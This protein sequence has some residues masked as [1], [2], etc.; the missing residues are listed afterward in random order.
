MPETAARIIVTVLAVYVTAGALFALAF[1]AA[2]AA[3]VDTRAAGAG[4]GFRAVVFPGAV[5]FWPLLAR[6]W[7][8]ARRNAP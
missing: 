1:V 8:R 6:R 5:L 2:G 7:S 3:R 4:W